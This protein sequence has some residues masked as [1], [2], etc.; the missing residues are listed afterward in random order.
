MR[1][2]LVL[3]GVQRFYV[4]SKC[5]HAFVL[6]RLKENTEEYKV[7][8]FFSS[9]PYMGTVSEKGFELDC[10]GVTKSSG[11]DLKGEVFRDFIQIRFTPA[12]QLILVP[13]FILAI[14]AAGTVASKTPIGKGA[15]CFASIFYLWM[16]VI[17]AIITRIK[18]RQFLSII[19]GGDTVWY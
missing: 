1:Q 17:M 9:K 14:L 3:I 13:I 11:L 10:R 5:N 6:D 7:F 19:G 16:V 12:V 8:R 15:L 2:L 4:Q 18:L